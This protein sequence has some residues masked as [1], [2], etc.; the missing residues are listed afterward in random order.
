MNQT[1]LN[2]IKLVDRN[3]VVC[4]SHFRS[5][6]HDTQTWCNQRC[7]EELGMPKIVKKSPPQKIHVGSM[8][9][10]EQKNQSKS[11]KRPNGNGKETTKKKST[12]DVEK[13]MSVT[14]KKKESETLPTTRPIEKKKTQEGKSGVKKT[15]SEKTKPIESGMRKTVESKVQKHNNVNGGETQPS[16]FTHLSVITNEVESTNMNLIDESAMHL[17]KLMKSKKD[18]ENDGDIE[19]SVRLAH[20]IRGLLKLKLDVIKVAKDMRV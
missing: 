20:E 11:V 13:G 8:E 9:R 3:C 6:E 14:K 4:G 1:S 18:S 17:F 2:E 15:E 19:N 10:T 7:Y 5:M 12:P 16:D